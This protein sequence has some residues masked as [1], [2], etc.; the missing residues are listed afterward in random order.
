MAPI[1]PLPVLLWG[2]STGQRHPRTVCNRFQHQNNMTLSHKERISSPHKNSISTLSMDQTEGR[3]LLAGSSDATL[4]IYDLTKWGREQQEIGHTSRNLYKPIA[5]SLRAT[6]NRQANGHSSSIVKAEWYAFDTGAF[7]SSSSDGSLLVWDTQEMQSVVQWQ[8]FSSIS[9][10]HLSKSAGRSES[11]VAVSSK[12]DAMI[13]L[14]DLRS[15]AASHSLTGH[16]RGVTSV[17]WCGPTSDV[18]IASA[19]LDGTVRLWDIRQAGSRATITVLDREESSPL[20]LRPY[21]PDYRH[22]RTSKKQKKGPNSYDDTTVLSHSGAVSAVAFTPDGHYLVSCGANQLQLWDLRSRGHLVTRK[23]TGVA[24]TPMLVLGQHVWMPNTST[25]IVS[26]PLMLGGPPT[27]VLDGHLGRVTALEYSHDSMQ[28]LSG[29]SDGMI[30]VW[31]SS[32][33]SRQPPLSQERTYKRRR[34]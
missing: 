24:S 32:Q 28:L 11:L 22:L 8:P 21:R 20:P 9:S 7:V 1:E 18:V 16:T 4:S 5:Q 29:G 30:L 3:F 34:R 31:S 14:V 27:Q 25:K 26:Y 17:Q 10:M 15:G 19:S 6:S 23:F 33:R 12:D 13:K 2:R